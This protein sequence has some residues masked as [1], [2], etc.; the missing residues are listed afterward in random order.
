MRYVVIATYRPVSG[1]P[2][3]G[4]SRSGRVTCIVHDRD[5]AAKLMY[6]YLG[7]IDVDSVKVYPITE[8][9]GHNPPPSPY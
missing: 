7:D 5:T 8:K 1:F 6:L 4:L 2:V 9:V 3:S